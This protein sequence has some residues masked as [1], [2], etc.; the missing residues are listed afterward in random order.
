MSPRLTASVVGVRNAETTTMASTAHRRRRRSAF[1]VTTPARVKKT[2]ARGS[3][4]SAPQITSIP[5]TNPRYRL[6]EITGSKAG[7]PMERRNVRN[8]GSRTV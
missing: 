4:N 5:I 7:W 1:G 2:M 8:S 6:M 3:S